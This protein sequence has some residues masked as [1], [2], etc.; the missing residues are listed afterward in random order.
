[1]LDPRAHD[2]L[3]TGLL[4]A[5]E[6]LQENV[7]DLLGEDLLK[8]DLLLGLQLLHLL[9]SKDRRSHIQLQA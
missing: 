2:L 7:G 4:S 9:L 5:R 3:R 6:A 8:E 1:M